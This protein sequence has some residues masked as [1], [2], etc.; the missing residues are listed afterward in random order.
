MRTSRLAVTL[1]GLIVAAT[2]TETSPQE[3]STETETVVAIL[4]TDRTAEAP[5]TLEE[6]VATALVNNAQMQKTRLRAEEL[7]GQEWR[8]RATGLPSVDVLGTWTRSRDPS[9]VLGIPTD[10]PPEETSGVI[11]TF[12]RT[13][14]FWTPSLGAR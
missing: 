5:L 4:R 10:L 3:L 1:G 2:P 14:T 8:A 12:D 13:Q 7:R 9:F 6:C 11:E